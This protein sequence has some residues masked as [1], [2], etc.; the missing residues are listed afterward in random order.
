[1]SLK[2]VTLRIEQDLY[3]QTK[4]IAS[5]SKCSFNS[6]VQNLIVEKLNF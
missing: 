1:M 5:K 3:E 4:N 6:F 2:S